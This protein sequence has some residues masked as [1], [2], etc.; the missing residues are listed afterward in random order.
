MIVTEK[1]RNAILAYVA[2]NGGAMRLIDTL[3]VSVATAI[4]IG[5]GRSKVIQRE[6]WEKLEP[7]I[8]PYM[9]TTDSSAPI[10]SDVSA[11]RQLIAAWLQELSRDELTKVI[12]FIAEIRA[13]KAVESE[14]RNR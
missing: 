9:A 2:D 3:G 1:I 14:P 7:L 13:G 5:K 11:E 4:H 12:A 8:Q 6:T 10:E